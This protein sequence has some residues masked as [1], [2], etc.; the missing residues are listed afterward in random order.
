MAEKNSPHYI[1]LEISKEFI[2]E[3]IGIPVQDFT[4]IAVGWN[5]KAIKIVTADK[6][7]LLRLSKTTWPKEKIL[8]EIAALEYLKTA[9]IKCPKIHS[10]G[11]GKVHWILMEYIDGKM[12]ESEWRS[13]DRITKL[14][15]IKQIG[16][17]LKILQSLHFPT[18]SGWILEKGIPL[19]T[20][21]FDGNY[22]YNSEAEFIISQYLLNVK[23]LESSM[24]TEFLKELE[25]KIKR[26]LEKLEH[27][28]I[29]FFHGDF[30][31]R[32]MMIKNNNL[33]SILDWEWA[34]TRP[35]YLELFYDLLEGEDENDKQENTW[36]RQEF[37]KLGFDY[38]NEEERKLLLDLVDATAEWNFSKSH[39]MDIVN[40]LNSFYSLPCK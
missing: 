7:L 17:Q 16:D 30:A 15:L 22:Q 5:N 31:F 13:L 4:E 37:R 20:R 8:N 27:V 12:L 39:L 38:P 11:F 25:P 36:I 14:N 2:S 3:L 9:D 23:K 18:I 40:K 34:G 1:D 29:V 21:Y 32:N 28:P 6:E 35:N 19:L 10:F 33:V 24:D 26:I